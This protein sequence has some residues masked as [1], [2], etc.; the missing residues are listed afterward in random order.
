MQRSLI[1]GFRIIDLRV[2]YAI[3]AVVIVFYMLFAHKSYLAIYHFFRRRFK[4]SPI[5]AFFNVYANHFRFGQVVIDRF[6]AYA[7][8]NFTIDVQGENHIN[9]L[10]LH[11]EGFMQFGAHAG[12]C[13]MAGYMTT[14]K[15]KRLNVLVYGGETETVMENRKKIFAKRNVNLIAVRPGDMSHI[16]EL[17]DALRRGEVVGIE[18]DRLFGSAKAVTCRF[19]GAEAA[20][21]IGPFMLTVQRDVEA[22]ALFVMKSGV[23]RYT[24]YTIVLPDDKTAPKAERARRMAEAYAAQLEKIVRLY[25]TQW[26]NYFEFWNE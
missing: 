13:E 9:R 25:P 20:F 8:K 22:V 23:R 6:A 5:H 1:A 17:N 7:G 14:S 21:P 15:D 16:F 11:D 3:M 26:Y 18:A 12:N 2:Y 24:A 10:A 19:L 4:Q